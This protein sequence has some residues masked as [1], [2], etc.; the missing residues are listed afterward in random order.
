MSENTQF[1]I[2]GML[3]SIPIG[4]AINLVTPFF[5]RQLSKISSK[6]AKRRIGKLIKEY[7][8]T[9]EYKIIQQKW[10]CWSP[11]IFFS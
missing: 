11:A 1:L 6:L 5:G 3:L 10:T 2:Y 8:R 4:I 9:K 7:N